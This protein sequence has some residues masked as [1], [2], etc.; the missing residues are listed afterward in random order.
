MKHPSLFPA[1]LSL[2]LLLASCGSQP[3][4]PTAATPAPNASSG[5]TESEC[6]IFEKSG[7]VIARVDFGTQK[8]WLD[9]VTTFEPVGG[10]KD[11]GYVLLELG[12]E[13]F[14]RLRVT[15]LMRGF[16]VKI[17]E[18]EMARQTKFGEIVKSGGLTSQSISGYSCY[19]TVEES[20]A[21]GRALATSYPN[22]AT[23][24]TFGQSW[25]KTK[26]RGGYDLYE[27]VLTN[28][29]KTG[30]KPKMLI[31]AAIHAREYTT[32]ELATRFG[33][34]LAA[35]YGKD[36]DITWMLD[37]Q[38][39]HI[40]FQ[41]NPDGRKKAESGLS[42][43]KNVN[44]TQG[45]CGT[46]SSSQY[47]IDM[48][49]NHSFGWGGA[50]ASTDPCNLTYRGSSAA[51]EPEVQSEQNLVN[52]L[53][54]DRRG[55]GKQDPAPA[56]T[57][58]IYI[59]LHSYSELVLWPYGDQTGAAPNGTALQ[60]L[61]RKLAYFN[62]Y[63]PQQ[64]VGLYPTSGG[65]DDYA[66]GERGVAS[67]TIELGKAFFENCTNFTSTILPNNQVALLYALKVARAPYLMGSGADVLNVAA[68]ASAST[69]FTLTATANSTRF[70]SVN[71]T[72]TT[73]TVT[74][75]EYFVDTAPWEGGVARPMSAADGSFNSAV[76][77]L[78]TTVSTAGLSSGQHIIYVRAKNTSG[79]YGPVSA[80]YVNVSSSTG[81]TSPVAS[82]TKTVSGL[83]VNFTS[84][85]TDADGSIASYAW[86]F[87]DGTTSTLANPT[88]T[89]SAA[90]TYN[91]TLTVKDNGGLTSTT[92]QSV[93]VSGGT[94]GSTTY[95]GNFVAG[96]SDYAPNSTGFTYAGG[97][98]KGVLTGPS[99][100]DFDLYLEKKST[101]TTSWTTVARSAGITANES[102]TYS[103]TSGTY[104]WKVT[105]YSGGGDITLVET[106]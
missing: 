3:S 11:Q 63:T 41:M 57:P 25:L 61:G 12:K 90:G 95:T 85:S 73:R 64:S 47:G 51:S 99:G 27:L 19:R 97:T 18:A 86:N 77:N 94:T 17:D 4:S 7:E 30:D 35:N 58:G 10:G 23:W 44:D 40:V 96:Q 79:N 92:T 5:A 74:G 15:G 68:P 59:D 105:A 2:T 82:F 100:T 52:T 45:S 20:Y 37:S 104:R 50:G 106:K 91:V 14:E 78:T 89:Y 84:T 31:T 8:N 93:T 60:S 70:S 62:D 21:A 32:A 65:S 87:G 55:P 42:W 43:R 49:R 75:A 33:E 88:K 48:N 46:T 71:G 22:L 80:V 67:Y 24:R 26:A 13:D 76:E 16:T 56:D 28:K 36:P 66:Y 103:A 81:N 34:Y 6:S 54:P 98:I 53:F 101:T 102:I 29:Q 9:I 69:S 83:S 38:E 39:V 1:V 72:E